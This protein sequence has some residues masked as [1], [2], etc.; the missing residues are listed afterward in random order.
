MRSTHV[1]KLM[2]NM[3]KGQLR[4]PDREDTAL[5]F[6]R[7]DGSFVP[8]SIDLRTNLLTKLPLP[9]GLVPIPDS[10]LLQPKW[11]LGLHSESTNGTEH[12]IDTGHLQ[13]SR[14]LPGVGDSIH[15]TRL[16][17]EASVNLSS[18]PTAREIPVTLHENTRVTPDSHWQDVRHLVFNSDKPASYNPGDVL[19]IFPKNY[20]EDVDQFIRQMGWTEVA[21]KSIDFISNTP[22][23]TAGPYL[24]PPLARA[25]LPTTLRS[26]LTQHL[27]FT[28]IPRRSFFSLIAHFTNDDFHKDRLLEFTKPEYIDEL[29]DYTTR[30]RRSI[31][32]VLQEFESVKIPWQWAA[33]VLPE[34]R[35]R[36]FSIASGGELKTSLQ[37]TA[38]FELLVAIV[39]YKTVIKK[40]RVGVC[41]QYL[42]NLPI[43][44]NLH[45]TLQK[46]GLNITKKEAHR[47]VVMI[48][49][50][51]GI[52]PMRSLI[53]ERLQWSQDKT[54]RGEVD[55]SQA[56][57]VPA[58]G[59]NLLFFGCRNRNADFFYSEEWEKIGGLMPLD[60]HSAFSRDQA[61]KVYVQDVIRQNPYAI[62][63]A[64]YQSNGIIY[65]C[66]SSGKMPRDVRVAVVDALIQ[67]TNM[68]EAEAEDYLQGMEKDGRYKQETW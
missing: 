30:P 6:S 61:N 68:D 3:M 16:S 64:L 47:R 60:V 41:T 40:I 46:G 36:Q 48:G 56:Q 33:V 23:E 28:A 7:L 12:T 19:T 9:Q 52:A 20:R 17:E 65:V 35:G 38:R 42:A 31:M 14:F 24:P 54:L 29:Y 27:D 50:G 51:T 44:T 5:K 43:G 4:C 32:E 34:L 57:N 59:H 18:D 13:V 26:L 66:G 15:D 58:I 55:Q 49:P 45:V 37:G 1:V 25:A 63:R 62:V 39:K 2:S 22:H 8:W 53:W 10:E 67:A 21:D 11:L